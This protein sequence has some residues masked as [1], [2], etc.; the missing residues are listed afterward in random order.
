MQLDQSMQRTADRHLF[1]TAARVAAR[2]GLLW[3]GLTGTLA[4]GAGHSV[5]S[6]AATLGVG[7]SPL[8]LGGTLLGSVG[9]LAFDAWRARRGAR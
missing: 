6:F 5:H 1:P 7:R 8:V 9:W 2:A 4:A 3:A